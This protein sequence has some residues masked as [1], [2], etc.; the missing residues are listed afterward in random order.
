[1]QKGKKILPP[2]NNNILQKYTTT[3]MVRDNAIDIL[4]G[5]GILLVVIGHSGCPSTLRILIY[6]THMPLFFLASGYFLN[7]E[8]LADTRNYIKGKIKSLYLPFLKYA[9]PF[10]F[11]HNLLIDLGVMTTEHGAR[12]YNFTTTLIELILRCVFMEVHGE[13]LLGTYWFVQALFFSHI[14]LAFTYSMLLR[15]RIKSAGKISFFA[16]L[17]LAFLISYAHYLYPNIKT[18]CLYRICMGVVFIWIGHLLRKNTYNNHHILLA[19]FVFVITF[20]I[21]PASM[22]EQSDIYDCVSLL[23]SGSCGFILLL[24][25]SQCIDKIRG[26]F[27]SK[28]SF[29]LSYM[30]RQSF[31]IMTFH[32]LSFKAVSLLIVLY[33]GWDDFSSIGMHPCITFV[34]ET[35]WWI[36]YSVAGIILSLAIHSTITFIVNCIHTKIQ[37]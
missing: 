5:I 20:I 4:K 16:F 6:M 30:G 31:Y 21:H 33:Y 32:F 11:F 12:Y 14:L 34:R 24:R 35:Y 37:H 15:K 28:I 9:L 2:N 7:V 27:L 17:T 26:Y 3:N 23:I 8:R 25:I 22:K 19:S 1:M 13:A 36:V 18:V 10:L 29:F